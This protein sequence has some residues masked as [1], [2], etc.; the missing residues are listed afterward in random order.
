MLKTY[1]LDGNVDTKY[2]LKTIQ[3]LKYAKVISKIS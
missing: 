2:C 3:I 1:F